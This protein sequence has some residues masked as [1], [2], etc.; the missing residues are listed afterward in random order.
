MDKSPKHPFGFGNLMNSMNQFF[1]EKPMK[2]MLQSIDEFFSSSQNPWGSFP[3]ALE[4]RADCFVITAEVP[5]IKKEQ[6]AL[7]IF[8]E[9]MT[10]NITR[11][12][13]FTEDNQPNRTFSYQKSTSRSSRSIA[14]P[15]TIDEAGQ[16]ASLADGILTVI[17][18]KDTGN[19][20]RIE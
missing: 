8:P 14:F 2:G 17:L 16:K 4:E 13:E 10:I 18:K 11:I 7:D 3:V 1:H 19:R 12:E 15:S 6:I 20:L 9:Y 5:G